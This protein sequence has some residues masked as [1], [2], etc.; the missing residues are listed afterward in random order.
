MPAAEPSPGPRQVQVV[1]GGGIALA[2]ILLLQIV[3]RYLPTADVFINFLLS[4][5]I[6][7]VCLNWGKAAG[8]L[9][10]LGAAVFSLIIPGLPAALP[11]M[12]IGGPYPLLKCVLGG[13]RYR[14]KT[15]RSQPADRSA[16]PAGSGWRFRLPGLLLLQGLL[17]LWFYLLL[18]L[19]GTAPLA[20]WAALPGWPYIILPAEVI[21]SLV[22]D[23]ALE[24]AWPWLQRLK[25]RRRGF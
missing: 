17:W 7:F 8:G 25:Q 20:H 2:A 9:V 13:S 24:Q 3:N 4:L 22:Y 23:F 19:A 11:F 21:F 15:A 18:K 1:A 16:R 5:I 10:Y 12:I 14:L 6:W